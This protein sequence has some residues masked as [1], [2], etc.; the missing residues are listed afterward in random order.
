MS[1]M[2]II[3]NNCLSTI[4]NN[5][6]TLYNIFDKM[7][8]DNKVCSIYF[9]YEKSL[10]N[11]P[12]LNLNEKKLLRI[13]HKEID[14]NSNL[15]H[16]ISE[17]MR[18]G[19]EIIWLI[20]SW[21]KKIKEFVKKNNVHTFFFLAGDSI[22][23][24]RIALYIKK[25]FDLNMLIYYT[26]D[27]YF[28][29]YFN[30]FGFIRKKI[31]SFYIKKS[32]KKSNEL[33]VISPSMKSHYDKVFNKNAKLLGIS[34]PPLENKYIYHD[35]INLTFTYIGNL[36]IGRFETIYRL[37]K[38]LNKI[39]QKQKRNYK[40]EIY[41]N[42]SLS[43]YQK[44]L[45][46][47]MEN[48]LLSGGLDKEEVNKKMNESDF[49]IFVESFDKSMIEITRYSFS[50][51]IM[52]YLSTLKPIISIGSIESSSIQILSNCSISLKNNN[53]NDY[54]LYKMIK[55]EK[56]INSNIEKSK[57]LFELLNDTF[58]LSKKEIYKFN[59]D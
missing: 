30:I 22:F 34:L 7:I 23:A 31:L 58:K 32:I 59:E 52:E 55:D 11:I 1:K 53:Y 9:S 57:A 46:L 29:H 13:K 40:M 27:Y 42:S 37:A 48:V 36:G 2:L 15:N 19:R 10:I 47:K 28:K 56:M 12:T 21:K 8:K 33:Y 5:G 16:Q 41:T 35:N 49:L 14:N 54:D 39:N 38:I 43:Y 17:C 6:K 3:S 24:Y 26:D 4:N 18:L 51:K 50:T 44:N 20:P 25:R 45:L